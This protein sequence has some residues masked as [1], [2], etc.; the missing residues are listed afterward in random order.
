MDTPQKIGEHERS[1]SDSG[2][3]KFQNDQLPIGLIVQLI[4]DCT[5]IAE[6]MGSKTRSSL[7]F[8]QAVI[9]RVVNSC[10]HKCDDQ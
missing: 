4:E 1:L 3:S 7:N 6:V 10:A 5:G 8:F 2:M 9:T